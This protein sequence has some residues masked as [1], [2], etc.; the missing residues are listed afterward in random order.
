[1]ESC[2]VPK[3]DHIKVYC[4]VDITLSLHSRSEF[5]HYVAGMQ[6][7]PQAS[8]FPGVV[9]NKDLDKRNQDIAENLDL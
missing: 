1:M 9:N 3:L 2:V 8:C 5:A 4:A 7:V 6:Y